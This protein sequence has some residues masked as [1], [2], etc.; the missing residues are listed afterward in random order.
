MTSCLPN[1]TRARHA[2]AVAVG[3]AL[4]AA[5]AAPAAAQGGDKKAGRR[6]AQPCVVC[7]GPI[8]ISSAP[9]TPHVA[10]QPEV[11]FVEQMKAYRTGKR[12][13]PAMNV[14]AKPLTDADMNDMAA[15]YASIKVSASLGTGA[16]GSRR[17]DCVQPKPRPRARN[18]DSSTDRRLSV[19]RRRP[20]APR[21]SAK[22]AGEASPG[23]A[24]GS[25]SS[26]PQPSGSSNGRT[27]RAKT[28]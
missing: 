21:R 5:T 26:T 16:P 15:W 14:V 19:S 24:H 8:G 9:D 1:R 13:H 20:P 18:P 17:P 22:G 28:P 25:G 6:K 27:S 7:H 23:G 4:A 3:I 10:G 12:V 2:L 11:Y